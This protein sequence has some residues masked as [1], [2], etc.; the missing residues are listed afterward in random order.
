M[1]LAHKGDQDAMN[2]II[3]E[4][5]DE[6]KVIASSQRKH[7]KNSL[8]TTALVNEAWLKLAKYGLDLNDRGHFLAVAATAMR[9]IVIDE[10]R[11]VMRQK[12]G[13]D[14][15]HVTFHTIPGEEMDVSILI[16]LD[17]A[18]EWLET[19]NQRLLDVFQLRYFVGLKELEIAEALNIS[20]RTVR[21]DWIKSCAILST[22]VEN[23]EPQHC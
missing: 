11:K 15:R 6:L 17:S 22:R 9:Q 1:Q 16:Q 19:K 3:N 13:G 5:Y 23:L 21:R 4:V 12:R 18:L 2:W 10:A 7:S 8:Q 14:Q 20:E